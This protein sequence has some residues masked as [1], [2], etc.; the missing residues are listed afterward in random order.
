[1][2]FHEA[3]KIPLQCLSFDGTVHQIFFIYYSVISGIYG[4]PVAQWL[5][6]CVSSA[7]VVCSIP[8]EHTYW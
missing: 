8:R 1:M 2:N 4:V 5:K 6:H 7:K 3:R